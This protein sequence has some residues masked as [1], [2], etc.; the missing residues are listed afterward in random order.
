MKPMARTGP[1][2]TEPARVARMTAKTTFALSVGTFVE[3]FDFAI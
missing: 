1:G 3:W 2:A